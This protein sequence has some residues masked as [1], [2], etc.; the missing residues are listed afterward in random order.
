MLESVRQLTVVNP[1]VNVCYSHVGTLV[2]NESGSGTSSSTGPPV[3]VET[4]RDFLLVSTLTGFV[5]VTGH[6]CLR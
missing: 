3:G 4:V 1:D 2:I 6:L 5:K